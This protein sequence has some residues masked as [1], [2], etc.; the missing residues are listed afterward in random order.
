MMHS[1]MLCYYSNSRAEI[2]FT[3]V[4]IANLRAGIAKL[5]LQFKPT[6]WTGKLWGHFTYSIVRP[7]P[8]C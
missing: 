4:Y 2:A 5:C 3:T 6:E 8:C 7:F 1:L